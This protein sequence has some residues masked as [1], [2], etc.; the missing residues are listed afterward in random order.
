MPSFQ[1]ISYV[2]FIFFYRFKLKHLSIQ[3][4]ILYIISQIYNVFF[5][6]SGTLASLNN[7]INFMLWGFT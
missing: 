5:E 6:P 1:N 2:Y 7:L 4:K 3:N